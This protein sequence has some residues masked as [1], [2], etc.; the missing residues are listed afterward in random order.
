M[1]NARLTLLGSQHAMLTEFL[2]AHPNGHEKAAIVLFRRLR[3]PIAEF[4]DSDRYIAQEIIPF[5]DAWV[6]SS[7]PAHIAFELASLRELF[8]KCEDD[9]LVF[10]FVH[11]H[12]SGPLAFSAIDDQNETTLLTALS[13]RNGTNIT[14]VSMLWA[15]GQWIARTRR[16]ANP[17]VAVPV[18]HTLVVA[19]RLHVYGYRESSADH[20]EVQARQAA[21]FGRPFVDILQSLRVAIVGCGGT[22]SPLATLLARS[23]IGELV[24]IDKDMLAKSNLNRVRGLTARDVGENKARRLKAFVDT[25]GLSVKVAVYESEIDTDRAALDALAS[26]DVVF[27]CTDDFAGRAVLNTA[28]YAYAQLLIDVG[29]GGRVVDDSDS[30]PTLRY[31]YGR[32]ST[33]LP[34][35]GQCLFCQDVLRNVWIQTQLARRVN[36]D[37]TDEELKERYLEDGG[38]GAPGV[39][40]FTSASA[41]F[42]IATLFDLIKPFRRFPPELRRDMFLID[43]VTMQLRSYQTEEKHDCPYCVK[44]DFLLMK[45]KYRLNQ[46]FL[47]K[48]DEFT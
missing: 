46:P 40:P 47:G 4:E 28:L 37:I 3:V 10:G 11:N 29:L 14:F 31:H 22:G 17:N 2:N 1:N 20:S 38:T 9:G 5:E 30:N 16:A 33:I 12:P 45:E 42:A 34:E 44:R 6:T 39:G 18:R 8:R 41:D 35:S 24:F 23:G 43:F 21:A 26:C 13:H 32:I 19:S 25:I 48:R 7:S 36:P 27:G 15:E